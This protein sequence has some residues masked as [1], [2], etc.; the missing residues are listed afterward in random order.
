MNTNTCTVD[1]CTNTAHAKALC[2]SH[3]RRLGIYG[4]PLGGITTRAQ[5]FE[6]KTTRLDDGCI[7]WTAR[8]NAVSGYGQFWDGTTT[9]YAHRW[10]YAKEHGP[11]PAGM[12]I[13]HTC[14]NR[15]C[16]NVAH[17]RITTRKQNLENVGTLRS[18]NTSGYRG[19]S[20]SK[21]A[22]KWWAHINHHGKVI[23][24]GLYADIHEANDA[25]VNARNTY[26]THNGMDHVGIATRT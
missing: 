1:G 2:R 24:V 16:V 17:L 15:A 10:A 3:Y 11:I 6:A 22:R 14:W 9:V 8:T 7:Q 25:V 18:D 19:V 13:D 21:Q 26:F 20:W 5:A 23:H 12:D 4:D